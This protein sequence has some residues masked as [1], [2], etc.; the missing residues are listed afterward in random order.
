MQRSNPSENMKMDNTVLQV[1]TSCEGP[2]TDALG[3]IV[4]LSAGND[5][6]CV[7][8]NCKN[9]KQGLT[10]DNTYFQDQVT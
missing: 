3:G 8:K 4:E 10:K 1:C 9:A 2:R 6:S 7:Y 5:L